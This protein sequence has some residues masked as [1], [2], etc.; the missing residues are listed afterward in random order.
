MLKVFCKFSIS[1]S[2]CFYSEQTPRC[3]VNTLQFT[4][5]SSFGLS[6]GVSGSSGSVLC[7]VTAC[8][9]HGVPCC[10]LEP[11][12]S[13]CRA[14]Q[15]GCTLPETPWVY[16]AWLLINFCLLHVCCCQIF[17]FT[18]S[19]FNYT[20]IFGIVSHSLKSCSSG[21]PKQL[22][23]ISPDSGGWEVRVR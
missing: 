10:V 3:P 19:I 2:L 14:W 7:S 12:A 15:H 5:Y 17:F 13:G 6:R 16:C 21:W 18:T 8:T 9:G 4:T 22:A 1:E 20:S 11:Q 23:F